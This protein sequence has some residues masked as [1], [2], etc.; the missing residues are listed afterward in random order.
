MTDFLTLEDINSVVAEYY[1][2]PFWDTVEIDTGES[3]VDFT[4]IKFDYLK[5]DR[6]YNSS[7]EKYDFTIVVENDLWAYKDGGQWRREFGFIYDSNNNPIT[8][9][10]RNADFTYSFSADTPNV[11]VNLYLNLNDT[12]ITNGFK[13]KPFKVNNPILIVNSKRPTLVFD[14]EPHLSSI[15]LNGCN[16]NLHIG[17]N[18]GQSALGGTVS[19]NKVTK[20]LTKDLNIGKT[21]GN[22]YITID[23]LNYYSII[24]VILLK[25]LNVVDLPSDLDLLV[26]RVN[27]FTLVSD[28]SNLSVESNYPVSISGKN[29]SLDLTGVYDVGN[30]NLTV[31]TVEDSS[32]YPNEFKFKLDTSYPTITNFSE[33]TTLFS[34]GG[35]GRLGNNITL[36]NDLTLTKDTLLIGNDAT[37][38]MNEHKIIVP[39][40]KTFKC[41]NTIFNGGENTIRQ[42][43]NSTVE[44]TSC[45]F[46]DCTCTDGHGA[47]IDCS[48]D[49]ESLTEPLDFTTRLTDCLISNCDMAIL[50]GGK[51]TITKCIVNGKVSNPSYP[52]FLYQTDG[53]ANITQTQ[54][55]IQSNTQITTD[56]EFNPCIF[57]CG[58][59]ALINN[60]THEEL[61]NNNVTSFLTSNR[62]NSSIDLTY[63]YNAIE[64]YITLQS[65]NGYCHS[66]SG[67][68]Y[69][70]K[71]GITPTR[72]G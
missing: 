57:T 30:V 43:T 13:N 58:A 26:G 2:V 24:G 29:V 11:V 38:T 60:L 33:L 36:T 18:S 50:H 32:Y 46:I 12:T 44:L 39:D 1:N 14:V 49:L 23:G 61:S 54:F 34:N 70:F 72:S 68:D 65:S 22:L 62:N 64:D 59:D 53:T 25:S 6:T 27:T 3:T 45:N 31:R 67:V 16:F 41:E 7:T 28:S 8:S 47:V 56:L 10:S 48:I 69:V 71:T 35:I 5:V 66:V 51:L 19:N 4:D 15:D 52:Y 63:Y 37:L 17:S 9:I 21:T 20:T 55:N 42:G 40:N